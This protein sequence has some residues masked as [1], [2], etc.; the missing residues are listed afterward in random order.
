ML[1]DR[2]GHLKWKR[3]LVAILAVALATAIR[4]E[5]LGMLGGRVL[6]LTYYPA[7]MVAAL[8]GGFPAGLLATFLSAL[9]A[10]L[11]WEKPVA[12]P[13]NIGDGLDLLAT[14]VFVGACS[15]ISYLA[16]STH[17]A[18]AM[19]SDAEAHAAVA[20][21]RA[22]ALELAERRNAETEAVI[23]AIQDAVLI[24]DT[25]MN[26]VRVNPMFTPTYG[27]DPVGLNL[28]DVIQ[29]TQCR[30]IDG[31]PFRL[32]EQPTPRAVRGETV[33]NQRFL[34]TRPDG[35][36]MALETSSGPFCV[37]SRIAGTVTV[38]H[39]IT[40]R[41]RAE[42]ELRESRE[43]LNR[44]Q[45]VAQTGSWRLNVQ[46]N[47][48]LWSEENHRI[49]GIPQ[50]TPMTY[51]TFLGVV[52]P[53]DRQYVHE[54]WTAGLS[55]AP[56]D[57]EHRLVVEDTVKWVRERA[58][59]EFDTEGTLLGGF[60]TTQDV[61][62]R[63]HT[64]EALRDSEARFRLLSETA[65][66]LLSSP[67]PQALVHKL[68]SQ[69]MVYLDCQ[70]FFNFLADEQAGRL[71]L[72]AWDGILD[73]EARKIEWLDY[74]VA[75]CDCAARDGVRMVAEDSCDVPDLR[76][77][78]VKSYGIKAYACHPLVAED[79][80]MGTLS[81]GTK[82]RTHFSPQDLAFMKTVT[83]QVAVAM[84]RKRLMEEQ[85]RSRDEL[86]M[87]VR[88]R[89]E[90]LAEANR[91]LE[92]SEE[93]LRK[94][95]ELLQ[96]ILDGITDPLIMLDREG[97]LRMIN[98]AARGYYRVAQTMDVLG[99]PCYLGLRA[100][101][102]PC[103][104]CNYPF[105]SVVS[106]TATFE[107][108]G[109]HDSRRTENITLYPLLDTSGQRDAIIIR[110]SDVTEAKLLE[111][112]ILQNEKLASLGLLTSG[113]AHEI[114]NPNSFI[115]FNI[116]ILN[117]Y[118]QELMPILDEHA[119]LHP[120]F[121]VL[122]MSYRDL[123]EDIFKLL[124]NMEHGSQRINNIVGVLKSFVRKRDSGGMQKVD[125]R[126]LIDKVVALCHAEMKHTVKSFELLVPA[127]LP[128]LI[129]DSEP[130]EQVL[131]NLLI[132]AIHACDKQESRVSLKVEPGC[133]G[134]DGFII[135]IT[136]NGSGIEEALR[137]KIFDPFFTTKPS[138]L[139]T[140]LGLYICHNHMESLGGAIE[141]ESSVG[142]GSTFR[143]L[144]PQMDEK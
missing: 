123:R 31:R 130:L 128:P 119:A 125:L 30:W 74:G 101:E 22:Q 132:N 87:R 122:H 54:K 8:Y 57:I 42:D 113:I 11:W 6:Y 144:L 20:A 116:P 39:D 68:C 114:N 121:E 24:Y 126:Q 84:E 50:G 138:A 12:I 86:E 127:N 28:R 66:R 72:N 78:L 19:A 103:P 79:R 69:V 1:W 131:L 61:T 3:Y 115:Y 105:L 106:E 55:G 40:E 52:H 118:L 4:A 120:D 35:V 99:K 100:R 49:F 104:E 45:V 111:R 92:A 96:K 89:T 90:E 85:Q 47:E 59:L 139:G 76:T 44:A 38:W 93:R 91:I 95:N 53:D 140:G 14:T 58:E 26:V 25:D 21:E 107:R 82:T 135:E 108:K 73:E 36:E 56:Y 41:M 60:G 32:E 117:K 27:F 62:E 63:K 142:Q 64:E 46:R 29:R 137:D 80:V 34:I 98:K 102:S 109:L 23:S 10:T 83:D 67:D 17:R 51:E 71:H 77:D 16:E 37:G 5:L 141:V 15:M 75:V 133:R 48:L 65:S 43:D 110:I 94:Y 136:D 97:L 112:Q 33:T 124:E 70:A 129:T 13:F 88:D 134:R 143:V 18:R 2:S 81:F 9:A 7:V